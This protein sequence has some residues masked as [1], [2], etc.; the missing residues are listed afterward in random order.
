MLIFLKECF[1]AINEGGVEFQGLISMR[2]GLLVTPMPR[3]AVRF[4]G[5]VDGP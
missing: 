4:K 3:N 5:C 1:D 2:M